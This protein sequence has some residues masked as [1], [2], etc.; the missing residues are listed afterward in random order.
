MAKPWEI[1]IC[2]TKL[3]L[4]TEVTKLTFQNLR[5]KIATVEAVQNHFKDAASQ[6]PGDVANGVRS[7]HNAAI[8]F[9]YGNKMFNLKMLTKQS[10]RNM[11]RRK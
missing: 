9:K 5:N 4:D 1:C 11:A 2:D 6:N 10:S 3:C 7:K 8:I